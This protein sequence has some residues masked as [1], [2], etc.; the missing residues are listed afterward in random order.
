MSTRRSTSTKSRASGSLLAERM[1]RALIDRLMDEYVSW[2]EECFGVAAAYGRWRKATR[3]EQSLTYHAYVA[4]L[5]REERAAATY[6]E[7]LERFAAAEP[8][9]RKRGR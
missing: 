2:R 8:G 6:R 5:D 4:A 1:R 7:L 9:S 3:D